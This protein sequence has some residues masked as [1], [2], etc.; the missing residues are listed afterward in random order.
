MKALI[1]SCL[2]FFFPFVAISLEFPILDPQDPEYFWMDEVIERDFAELEGID[3]PQYLSDVQHHKNN[4]WI[5]R[6]RI[7]D[8]RVVEGP[9]SAC[10]GML[11]YL[12][13]IYGL[14]DL[15]FLN[16]NQDGMWD[17]PSGKTP[18]LVGCRQA[19]A[20]KTILFVDWYFNIKDPETGWHRERAIIDGCYPL[21][22]SERENKVFWR[23]A[24]TDVWSYGNYSVTNWHLHARGRAV[25]LST[26][27]PE[28]V[29]AAFTHF[30]HFLCEGGESEVEKLKQ[31]APFSSH[32]KLDDH[33]KY[34]YQLDI[35]G[36]IGNFARDRWE[37]YSESVIFRYCAGHEL[38]WNSLA[39]PWVHFI[40]LDS[41]AKDLIEKIEW[42]R[43]HDQECKAMAIASRQFAQTH[44]MPEHVALYCYKVLTRYAKQVQKFDP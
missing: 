14:P 9:H 19:G 32:V 3:A 39:Q 18:I 33:L 34:K 31:V 30:P 40:P 7:K 10:R 29:D 35:S 41:H 25:Y 24:A 20:K 13:E 28:H 38:F 22:W 6:F 5:C 8:N 23:G 4:D 1:F 42:A 26:L 37:F 11:E 12:C 2:C 44:F 27:Y 17:G 36:L 43:Q 16:W 15:D 21:D